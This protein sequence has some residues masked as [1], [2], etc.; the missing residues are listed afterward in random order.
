VGRNGTGVIED[1]VVPP[2]A[3]ASEYLLMGLRVSEGIDLDRYAELAGGAVDGAKIGAM[4]QLGLV[5]RVGAR[6]SAT[7]DGRRVLNA[8][9]AELAA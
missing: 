6:L 9:I 3:Q 5:R 4:E 1:Q 2:E 7:H 8:L